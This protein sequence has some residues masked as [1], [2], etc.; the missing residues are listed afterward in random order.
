MPGGQRSAVPSIEDLGHESPWPP[1]NGVLDVLQVLSLVDLLNSLPSFCSFE[2]FT[3]CVPVIC[4]VQPKLSLSIV[5]R[6]GP[7]S[8]VSALPFPFHEV[9]L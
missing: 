6:F 1:I 9:A 8:I 5:A 3:E 4:H 2:L 7:N